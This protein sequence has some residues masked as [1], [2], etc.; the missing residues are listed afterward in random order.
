MRDDGTL[1]LFSTITHEILGSREVSMLLR[2]S[3]PYFSLGCHLKGGDERVDLNGE[4]TQQSHPVKEC[5]DCRKQAALEET[6]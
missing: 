2:K 1:W 5:S 3:S 4:D 6:P